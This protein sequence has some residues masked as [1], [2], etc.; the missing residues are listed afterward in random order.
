V[1][2]EAMSYRTRAPAHPAVAALLHVLRTS[3]VS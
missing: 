1:R 2:L 3:L